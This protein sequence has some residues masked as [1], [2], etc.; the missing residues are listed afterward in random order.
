MGLQTL[1]V[2]ALVDRAKWHWHNRWQLVA[3]ALPLDYGFGESAGVG[4]DGVFSA[5]VAS[6]DAPNLARTL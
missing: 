6:L 3:A 5:G 4:L 2:S 1:V